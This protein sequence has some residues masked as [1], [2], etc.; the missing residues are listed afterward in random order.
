MNI[1]KIRNRKPVCLFLRGVFW[2]AVFTAIGCSPEAAQK[3][4]P[5][6]GYEIVNEYPHDHQAFTQ[7]LVFDGGFLYESTGLRKIST[8]RKTD[9]VSGIVLQTHKLADRYFGEGLTIFGDRII[10]LTWQSN[11]GFVYEK[12][13]FKLLQT[14][15]YPGQG[16]GITHDGKRLIMSDGTAELRILDPFT[17]EEIGRINV[18]CNGMPVK[19][20]NEL[21]Y[22]RGEIYANVWEQN[23]IAR[24]NPETGQ[25][26]GWIDLTG[27]LKPEDCDI[28][29]DVLNGIAY[30]VAGGRLFVTGKL[31]PKIFE[32]KLTEK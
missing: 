30:D 4:V 22:V 6:Y 7:G 26:V 29:P 14:F 27:L 10:Q 8:L 12:D 2:V 20:L 13:S 21:E 11:A 17:F 18:K 31:W 25:V 3:I 28:R 16:W 23:Q 32:I 24:I 15:K 1:R 9:L 19:W 5:V